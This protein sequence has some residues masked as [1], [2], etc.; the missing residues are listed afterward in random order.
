MRAL[1]HADFLARLERDVST[2]LGPEA[3][4]RIEHYVAIFRTLDREDFEDYL[5]EHVQQEI[6]DTHVHTSW[7]PCPAHPGHPLW[8][9]SGAW[10][11]AVDPSVAVAL[12]R[13]E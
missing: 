10:R 11:C 13:V 9:A 12:G 1:A 8:F 4:A 5:A 7:P 3:G 2:V 6:L